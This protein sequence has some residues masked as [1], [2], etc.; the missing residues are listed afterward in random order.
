M[1]KNSSKGIVLGESVNTEENRGDPLDKV[2]DVEFIEVEEDK[3]KHTDENP[4][5]EDNHKIQTFPE[6]CEMDFECVDM[7]PNGFLLIHNDDVFEYQDAFSDITVSEGGEITK[8]ESSFNHF[9]QISDKTEM[10]NVIGLTV[11]EAILD[12]KEA[13]FINVT[14]KGTSNGK[15]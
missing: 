10:I 13:G 1:A 15:K 8:T 12:L 14:L 6:P 3:N 4:D 9:E 11:Q 7:S 2:I 5:G